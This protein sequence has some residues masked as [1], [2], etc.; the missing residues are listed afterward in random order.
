MLLLSEEDEGLCI[1][2]CHQSHSRKLNLGLHDG[3]AILD[4]GVRLA[5]AI[6][7]QSTCAHSYNLSSICPPVCMLPNSP[8][9]N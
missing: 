3:E 9:D 4:K 7:Q 1:R 8:R 6:L 2:A 5:E